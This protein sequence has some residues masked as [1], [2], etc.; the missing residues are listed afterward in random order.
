MG[1]DGGVLCD[2]RLSLTS[3]GQQHIGPRPNNQ[4]SVEASGSISNPRHRV[5]RSSRL[6]AP[7]A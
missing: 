2:S 5:N 7:M 1:F 3:Q 4:G 6:Q